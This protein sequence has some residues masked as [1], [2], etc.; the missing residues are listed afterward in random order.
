MRKG[1]GAES[2]SLSVSFP[3]QFV[4]KGSY[5]SLPPPFLGGA[6]NAPTAVFSCVSKG[7]E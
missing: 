4:F 3:D 7:F 2:A 5:T 6:A 1:D